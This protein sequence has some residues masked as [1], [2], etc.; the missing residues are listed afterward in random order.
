MN[1]KGLGAVVN[2]SRKIIYAFRSADGEEA[3]DWKAAV[4]QAAE[5]TRDDLAREVNPPK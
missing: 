4:A 5:A 3:E 1:D 2:S